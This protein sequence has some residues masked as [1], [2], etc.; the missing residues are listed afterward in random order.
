M[1]ESV[2]IERNHMKDTFN[3]IKEDCKEIAISLTLLIIGFLAIRMI[4]ELSK[5]SDAEIDKQKD[6]IVQ[7]IKQSDYIIARSEYEKTVIEEI[8]KDNNK[9][10]VNV[11]KNTTY[12][13]SRANLKFWE[14]RPEWKISYKEAPSE[15][16]GEPETTKEKRQ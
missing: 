5:P 12:G 1:D 16:T 10:I 14:M 3:N 7:Q 8:L 2:L 11:Q 4:V 15:I 13:P 9:E 6:K